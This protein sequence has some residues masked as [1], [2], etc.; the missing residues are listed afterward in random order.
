MFTSSGTL[1]L[2]TWQYI[3]LTLSGT[4]LKMYIN[5]SLDSTHTISNGGTWGDLSNGAHLGYGYQYHNARMGT[6]Q[7]YNKELTVTEITHNYNATKD[8]YI[9]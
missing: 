9:N 8:R 7:V 6:V 3:T 4:T 1:S 2:N 5:T